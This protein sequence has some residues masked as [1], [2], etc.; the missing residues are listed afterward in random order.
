MLVGDART[1]AIH[2]TCA[3]DARYGPYAGIALSSVLASN[4]DSK[5]C[6]HL[7]SDSIRQR[8]IQRI[9]KLV[10]SYGAELN[11]Y[12]MK[13]QLDAY[14][15][16]QSHKHYSRAA[17]IRLFMPEIVPAH[18]HWI[19]YL[20]CDVICQSSWRSIW[21]RRDEVHVIGAALDPWIDR[22]GNYKRSLGIPIDQRYYGSGV[23]LINVQTWRERKLGDKLL[24]F[25]QRGPTQYIDQDAINYI[26]GTEI[27]ELP[28]SWNALV[29]SP[30]DRDMAREIESA[31]NIHYSASFKPWHLGYARFRGIGAEAFSRAKSKSPWRWLLPDFHLNRVRRKLRR[32]LRLS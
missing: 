24:E 26:I 2:V 15:S 21:E 17:Y 8:D 19:V 1:D 4:H 3:A 27:T 13:E 10:Q 30:D 5:V 16:L 25:V 29:T 32:S 31:I 18:V 22:D 6:I 28:A 11:L 14:P 7:F 23:L 20:D 9:K 12:D